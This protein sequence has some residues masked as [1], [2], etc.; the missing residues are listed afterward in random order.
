MAAR[1]L[2]V[3]LL[4][5]RAA[6]ADV[7]VRASI[8]P[9]RLGV[10]DS[11]ELDV[12]VDGVQSASVPEVPPVDGVTVSYVGPSTEVSIVNGQTTQS[13][14]H[15]F[16]VIAA[17]AGTFTIGPI[18][19][20][21]GGR[22]YQA[23]AVTLTA[24]AAGGAP[25][26]QA[27]ASS[28]E[29]LRLVLSAAKTEVYLHE[30]VPL[31]VE[32]YVGNVRVSGLQ[33]PTIPGD[34]IAIDKWPQQPAQR[35]EQT[36]QGVFQVLDFATTLTPL[37][38]GT[39]TIGPASTSFNVLVR[40]RTR[41]QFFGFFSEAE[42]PTALRSEPLTLTVLPLPDAGRPAD[43]TG[44]VGHFEVEVKAAPL[45]LGVGD[46]VTVTITIRGVGNL[47]SVN[48][49][50]I[51][52]SD[53]LRVY[54]VQP[55]GRP[56]AN[57]STFEQVVIPQ[58]AGTIALPETR[59]SYFDPEAR[60]Y[61]TAS[62]P[63][64]AL[65]V[66]EGTQPRA[67][68]EI[69][70]GGVRRTPAEKLG[71]DLV[72]IKDTPG[73]FTRVGA[74]R[75]RSAAFWG[76]QLLPLAVWLV[77]VGYDRRRRRLTGDVR[78][79]RF[80][81]AGRAARHAIA[82]ARQKLR[83]GEHAAFYDALARAVSEYLAAKLDLPPG[84]VS[85]D[86]VGARLRQHDVPA[87]VADELT[88]FFATCE[89]ARFA[90]TA[91]ASGD[92]QR[93]LDRADAIVRA[94]ERKRRLARAVAAVLLLV[95]AA[96][97]HAW[98]APAAESPNTIFFRG[99]T[100]YAEE[101]YAEASAQYEQLLAAGL[102]SGNLYFNLGNAYFR[103]GDVG[104]AILDYERARRLIPGDPDLIANLG[105]ARAV[106]GVSE[107]APGWERL[108]FPLAPRFS[109]DGLLIVASALWALLMLLLVVARLSAPAARAART[110]AAVTGLALAVVLSSAAYRLVTVDLPIYAVVV[111][112]QAVTV[113]FE[114]SAGG[115][116]HFEAKPGTVLRLEGERQGW[117]QVRRADGPRGW[118]QRDA[119]ATL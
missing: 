27:A 32:L 16:S 83:A 101:R 118:I 33:Y 41:D 95:A 104:R 106:A 6:A 85:P 66:R 80:T 1:L 115:T 110:A 90:P 89:R 93:T 22:R 111:E 65:A 71:S 64:I 67:A 47:E 2:A 100:L 70:G 63:P 102:E 73:T 69:V 84:D 46:P 98:A 19:V 14:T 42:R 86:T 77:V 76:F 61:R 4:L 37:R 68:P 56:A 74:R 72:F 48:P 113:R 58:R 79:A 116:A 117:A 35:S 12:T 114:P 57:Q 34:G 75:Y 55:S 50:G 9:P 53:T 20:V 3:L 105:Y 108:L 23:A 54:P 43:F 25:P 81:R 30:R 109:S 7:A 24:A 29:Q 62:G 13:I 97:T 8:D 17:R 11:A 26:G 45:A 51:A 96:A 36:P 31:R 103:A 38:G 5:A 99:N 92:M 28:G 10:G 49:P 59:F 88:E 44:A 21:V 15:R 119:I 39:L 94:L 82:G 112:P 78:Y 52:A 91:D 18:A 60:A 40:S 87:A 107:A